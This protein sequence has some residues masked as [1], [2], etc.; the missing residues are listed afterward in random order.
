[1][2]RVCFRASENI[3]R[4]VFSSAALLQGT[5]PTLWAAAP[6]P[7]VTMKSFGQLPDGRQTHLFTL[8]NASG[9]RAEISDL[10]GTVVNLFVPDR[11]GQLADVSLGF[12]NAAQYHA[13][14]P[15]FGALIGRYGNRIAHGRFTLDGVT[16]SLATNNSPGGIPCSLHGGVVGF[17]KVIWE[18]R[19][20]MVGGNPALIL[21]YTSRDGE[22]GYPGKLRVEVTYTVTPENEL[23][24]DYQATTTKATPVNLTNHT[25]FN[26]R[27]EGVGT[28]LDHVVVMRASRTTPVN[29]GLIPTGA[30]I[31]VA[32]TP[33]DFTSPHAIGERIDAADEQLKFGGGYD[34]NW[35]LDHQD[36]AL[37]LA[38]T[39]LEPG[40]GRFMEILTTEPGLQFYSGN[41]LDGTLTGKSGKAYPRRSGFCLETQHY[42]DSPNH[43]DFPSTILR[44]GE[45]LRSTTIYRFSTK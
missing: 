32:G 33:L 13:Q 38:A 19:P 26:L 9:F 44:P 2:L 41:F 21:S 31:P 11:T 14:A 35:V 1:M 25:Y 37:A 27:G 16:Y 5:V 36:G 10:G 30:I 20:V 4:L 17:D 12:D 7:V 28:I 40:S 15:F 45:T 43:P 18:A 6:G 39:V 8:E 34:H 24:L 3:R 42:P 29:A 23:R 22:E